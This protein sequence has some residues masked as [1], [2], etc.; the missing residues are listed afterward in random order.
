MPDLDTR[1][2]D[3]YA[4]PLDA[5]IPGRAALAREVAQ[6]GDD[7][8]GARIKRLP[9]PTL[10]AWIVNQVVRER[11]DDVDAL[12]ALGDELRDATED[13]DRGRIT[14]LDRLRRTRVDGLV[15]DV[16]AAGSIGGRKVSADAARRLGETLTA[17]VMDDG[18]A[19]AVRSGR[20]AQ[21]LQYVGF[22]MVDESGEPA[23]VVDLVG[24]AREDDGERAAGGAASPEAPPDD[25]L[26]AAEREVAEAAAEVDRV[27]SRRDDAAAEV[28]AAT[29]T[30]D[31]L[32]AEARRLDDEIERLSAD[33]QKVGRRRD[34]ASAAL[35]AAKSKLAAVDA[36]LEDAEERASA[37]RRRRREARGR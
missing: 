18:A 22:G 2:A 36:A 13:R 23:D 27:E 16:L 3:L 17:V 21:A 4:G 20:L 12:A 8:G 11:P 1:I 19:A 25:A 5:F 35:E 29:A 31:P 33:R 14:A 10:A 9:K 30:L 28:K 6:G 26:A 7:V 37:A 24:R 34:A 15:A 32:E